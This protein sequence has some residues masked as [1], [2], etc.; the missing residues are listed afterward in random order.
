MSGKIKLIV[1]LTVTA[2]VSFGI[3][4][5]ATVLLGGGD[6]QEVQAQLA[7]DQTQVIPTVNIEE[8]KPKEKMLNHLIR[9][10]RVCISD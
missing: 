7:A 10:L 4:M 2:V 3:S 8:Q 5:A 6:A 9:E 1:I